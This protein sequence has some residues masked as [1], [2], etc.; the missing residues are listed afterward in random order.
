MV[1]HAQRGSKVEFLQG[2]PE[3]CKKVLVPNVNVNCHYCWDDYSFDLAC[4]FRL[5]GRRVRL[6]CNFPLVVSG[7]FGV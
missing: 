2:D 7:L 3:D 1:S 4:A 6:G 5:A